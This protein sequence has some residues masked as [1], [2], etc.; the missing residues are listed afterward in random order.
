MVLSLDR[1]TSLDSAFNKER[2]KIS[3]EEEPHPFL[4][5]RTTH[6]SPPPP[7]LFF[8]VFRK[9]LSSTFLCPT[10]TSPLPSSLHSFKSLELNPFF[11]INTKK[12]ETFFCIHTIVVASLLCCCFCCY[13]LGART[14]EWPFLCDGDAQKREGSLILCNN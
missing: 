10:D 9:N 11:F 12:N 4:K 8:R 13:F 5:P 2:E 3:D 14:S 6:T 7:L 1:T